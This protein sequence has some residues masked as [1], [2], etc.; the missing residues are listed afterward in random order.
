MQIFIETFTLFKTQKLNN[1]RQCDGDT[2]LWAAGMSGTGLHLVLI[3]RG[4][5]LLHC[6]LINI[7]TVH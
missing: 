1:H 2:K 7:E 3:F 4:G 5:L 6:D